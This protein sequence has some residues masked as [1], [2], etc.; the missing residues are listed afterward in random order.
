MA[1][2]EQLS[3]GGELLGHAAGVR[4][5]AFAHGAEEGSE[6]LASCS[7]DGTLRLWSASPKSMGAVLRKIDGG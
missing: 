5:L 2:G 6:A 7:D 1:S 4:G 3:K